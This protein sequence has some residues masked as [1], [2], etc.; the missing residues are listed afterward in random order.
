MRPLVEEM[1]I[2]VAERG[3]KAVRVVTLPDGAG[4][5]VEAQPIAHRER[6]SGDH[7]REQIGGLALHRDRLLAGEHDLGAFGVRLSRADDD[8]LDAVEARRMRAEQT[9]R[10]AVTPGEKAVAV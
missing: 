8:A 1:Q 10:I 7:D 4:G 2:D 5:E 9:M 3:R 6:E